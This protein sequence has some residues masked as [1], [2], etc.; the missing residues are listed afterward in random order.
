MTNT[1]AQFFYS[2]RLMKKIPFFLILLLIKA[3]TSQQISQNS[4]FYQNL[5]LINPA[6]VGENELTEFHVSHRQQWLG[7]EGAP[8]T[9]WFSAQT[10]INDKFGVGTKVNYDQVSFFKQFQF[11]A[12]A[13]YSIKIDASNA[14]RFGLSLGIKQGSLVL[15]NMVAT[16]YSDY[17]L[18]NNG[19]SGTGFH[20]EFGLNYSFKE[21]L[22]IGFSL[23]QL[24]ASSFDLEPAILNNNYIFNSHRFFYASYEL[25]MSKDVTFTPLILFKKASGFSNL[26]EFQGNFNFQHKFWGGLGV[27]QQNG[28]MLNVGMSPL[29]NI[30]VTY[31]YE[32]NSN[33]VAQFSSGTHEIML[34]YQ[35]NRKK[36]EKEESPTE[37]QEIPLENFEE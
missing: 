15:E 8:L 3:A 19:T 1:L 26:V 28:I 31:A 6:E 16:D 27:R 11:D 32:F 17:L 22:T 21:K 4:L 12:S 37:N 24:F 5:F 29:N 20:S 18:Q 13:S 2:N 7:F 23:P 36:Q 25:N 9:T 34:S 35:I 33:G 14:I 10:K 30:N